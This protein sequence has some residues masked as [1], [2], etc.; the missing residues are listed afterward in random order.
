MAEQL[1]VNAAQRLQALEIQ[2]A[3][4]TA[5]VETEHDASVAMA[6]KLT[7]PQIVSALFERAGQIASEGSPASKD[8]GAR[9]FRLA[10][11]IAEAQS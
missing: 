8:R 9:L 6:G 3:V 11:E 4:L 5:R 10:E 1:P 2:V 7:V